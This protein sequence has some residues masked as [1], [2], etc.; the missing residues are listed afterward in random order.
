M[1]GDDARA[2]A[3]RRRVM[4]IAG[5]T[6]CLAAALVS[7]AS[8]LAA[9]GEQRRL[10][11]VTLAL[12]EAMTRLET[13]IGYGGLIH[14]FKNWVL[15]PEETR[16]RDAVI[17]RAGDALDALD[18]LEDAF[19]AADI[20]RDLVAQRT[21]IEGYRN[22]LATVA[23]LHRDGASAREIDDAVRISD[24]PAVAELRETQRAIAGAIAGRL[25]TLDRWT[26][27]SLGAFGVFLALALAGGFLAYRDRNRR[28]L[29]LMRTRTDDMET[30]TRIAA[31]DL[32]SPLQQIAALTR[33]AQEDLVEGEEVGAVPVAT[34]SRHL[35]LVAGRVTRLD[36]LVQEVFRY[37]DAGA[38]STAPA[39]IDLHRMLDELAEMHLPHGG[40]LDFDGGARVI[41]VRPLEF[42][43]VLRNLIS[44]AVKHHP[45]RRPAITVRHRQQGGLHRFEIEDDGPGIPDG[46]RDRIFKLHAVL[47]EA[48]TDSSGLGLAIVRRIVGSWG[49]EV[50]VRNAAHGGAVFAFS[51]PEG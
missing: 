33:I 31:H 45:D 26:L 47:D 25:A 49:G 1:A 2:R 20:P 38:G 8:W 37:I 29:G 42:E 43:T 46:D 7:L 3:A 51:L 28:A 9:V 6:L 15:R 12:P 48:R 32:R 22:A 34:I 17:A 40:R 36:T 30:F 27:L 39:E 50:S 16:Y 4:E 23:A 44:N 35:D 14:D 18:D 13:A 41:R 11:R 10:A 19:A 21:V 5:I 24:A